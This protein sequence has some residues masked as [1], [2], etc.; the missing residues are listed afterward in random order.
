MSIKN[1]RLRLGKIFSVAPMMDWTDRHCRV[2]HRHLAPRAL[3]FTEMVTA[4]AIIHGNLERL[5]GHDVIEH[6]LVLQLGGSQPDRLARAVEIAA[7]RGF[8]EIKF[9]RVSAAT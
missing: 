7:D 9:I 3:L 1:K 8:C 5:I 6:P 2:F 4:A